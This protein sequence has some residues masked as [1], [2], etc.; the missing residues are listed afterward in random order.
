[1]MGS[2]LRLHIFKIPRLSGALPSSI[3]TGKI[4]LDPVAT[5]KINLCHR[6]YSRVVYSTRKVDIVTPVFLQ[7]E[8]F[9]GRIAIVDHKSQYTYDDLLHHS[10]HFSKQLVSTY[11]NRDLEGKSVAF[12]C[13]N[14]ISYVIAQWAIWMAGGV[15]V[16][17]CKVH[18]QTELEYYVE[19]SKSSI[20]IASEEFEETLS[21]MAMKFDLPLMILNS[22]KC[23]E[24]YD[25]DENQ[26]FASD[27]QS[28]KPKKARHKNSRFDIMLMTNKFKNTP[29]MIVYTSGTTDRPK[30]VVLTH[31]NLY[32]QVSGML[33]S[34][35]WSEKDVLL[36]TLP[37]HHVHGIVNCLM[38]PLHIGATCYMLPA[39][40]PKAVWNMLLR[41]IQPGVRMRIN[42]Y[43]AVPTMYAKLIEHFE[44]KLS[45]GRGTRFQKNFVRS[46]CLNRIRLMVSGSAALPQT[47]LEKWRDIT[48]H[49]LLERYGMTEVGMALSNPLDGARIPGAVGLPL[50]R[51]EVCIGKP[52]VYS[53][54]GYDL[55]ARGNS[56]RTVIT[57]GQAGEQGEL[58]VRGPSVFKEY[59][60]NPAATTA[61]FT[62]DG[63]F[64]TGDI[65]V[66][67]DKVYRVIGRSSVDIIK[68]GGYKISALDVERHLLE[69][70]GISECAVVGL[71]D[72]TWGQKVAVV[73]V[74]KHGH[75]MTLSELRSWAKN[76]VPAYQ[77]PTVLE[78]LDSIP[79][80]PMGKINKKHL[81]EDIFSGYLQ[82]R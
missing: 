33:E 30:G 6:C 53:T 62:E 34:W 11:G 78:L 14:D 5:S 77:L 68:S 7:A 24:Q 19:N 80:N 17:L 75:T 48:G 8:K 52:N 3:N 43:M 59:W 29:A 58:M 9:L 37:L 13:Q 81:V 46:V 44:A 12:L 18:P 10:A 16:P 60:Q 72:L 36:H 49:T 57:R 45:R 71:P 47:I 55:L 1:M 39:F 21:S 42:M 28:P 67:E 2:S 20:L 69:H 26:W 32:F 51:V 76:K 56:K 22:E 74:L 23:R 31:G 41:P 4:M 50:P 73:V 66:Y 25:P 65:A 61:A 64:K 82:K 63:W 38:T 70:P 54:Y 79:R 35:G 27:T 40:E 15:A